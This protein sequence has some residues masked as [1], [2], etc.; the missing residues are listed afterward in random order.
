M[1]FVRGRLDARWFP[2]RHNLALFRLAAYLRLRNAPPERGD[3]ILVIDRHQSAAETW[4]VTTWVTL[5]TACFMSAT[6]FARWPVAVALGVA[7]PLAIAGLEVPAIIS[8]L[9]VAPLYNAI[10]PR[11]I[12]PMRVNAIFVM[13]LLA[14]VSMYFVT[15]ATW[16]RFVAWQFLALLTLNAL[17]APIVFSLR[18]SIAR[19]EAAVGGTP[20]AV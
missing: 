3:V 8:A 16:V 17:A 12:A 20:S 5:T 2:S 10:A 19:L 4:I 6:L 15:Q 9:T 11:R 7:V 14:A 13:A 18:D 1:R